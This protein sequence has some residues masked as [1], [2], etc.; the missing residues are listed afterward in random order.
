[1]C[2]YASLFLLSKLIFCLCSPHDCHHDDQHPDHP[3]HHNYDPLDH[4]LNHDWSPS[5]S[6]GCSLVAAIPATSESTTLSR[7]S[8]R[9]ILVKMRMKF[10]ILGGWERSWMMGVMSQLIWICSYGTDPSKGDYWLVMFCKNWTYLY[11]NINICR[12]IPNY[13]IGLINNPWAM[14]KLSFELKN[15]IGD[16]GSTAL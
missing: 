10:I 11:K 3:Q 5:S 6:V 9:L 12:Q 15:T 7:W 4:Q 2:I 16:G 1:M 14:A 13:F 8:G